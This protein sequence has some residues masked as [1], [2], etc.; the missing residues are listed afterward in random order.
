MAPFKFDENWFSMLMAQEKITA[1]PARNHTQYFPY[2]AA[3][4]FT[5]MQAHDPS[6]RD[7]CISLRRSNRKLQTGKMPGRVQFAANSRDDN[8]AGPGLSQRPVMPQYWVR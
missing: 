2:S 4:P 5:S 3:I 1:E 7:R 6:G 8:D